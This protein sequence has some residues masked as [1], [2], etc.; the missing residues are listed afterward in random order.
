MACSTVLIQCVIWHVG[1]V[2][3]QCV[4][5]HVAQCSYIKCV[6]WHVGTVLIQCVMWHVRTVLIQCAGSNVSPS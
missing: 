4:M 6:I 2:L 3:I 5:W 1:T